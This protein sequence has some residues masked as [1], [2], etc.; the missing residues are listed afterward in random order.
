MLLLKIS[1]TFE[2]YIISRLLHKH[3]NKLNEID[4]FKQNKQSVS[5]Q[6][7]EEENE[8]GRKSK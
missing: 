4:L 6:K 1:R 2:S 7:K 8:R 3:W 5:V